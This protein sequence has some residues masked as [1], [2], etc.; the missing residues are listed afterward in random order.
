[1]STTLVRNNKPARPLAD[2]P[3]QPELIAT[4][5]ETLLSATIGLLREHLPSHEFKI[6]QVTGNEAVITHRK[7]IKIN[8]YRIKISR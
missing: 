7:G 5:P 3:I 1:M 2:F 8:F 6:E 4:S